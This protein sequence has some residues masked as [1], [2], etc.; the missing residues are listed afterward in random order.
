MSS[1]SD[2]YEK[3]KAIIAKQL[4]LDDASVITQKARLTVI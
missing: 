2:T 3:L 1:D 4:E